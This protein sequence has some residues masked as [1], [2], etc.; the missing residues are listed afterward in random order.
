M[1]YKLILG[2]WAIFVVAVMYWD[3]NRYDMDVNLISKCHYA[4]IFM[5]HG[6]PM[7][8]ECKLF[9]EVVDG[10]RTK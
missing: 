10:R 4:E 3:M 6:R 2:L 8:T 5:Y 1:N 7:C 9:C